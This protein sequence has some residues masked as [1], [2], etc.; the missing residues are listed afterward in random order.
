MADDDLIE[1][2]LDEYLDIHVPLGDVEGQPPGE[3]I[4]APPDE[5]FADRLLYKARRLSVEQAKYQRLRDRR[6]AEIDAWLSDRTAGTTRELGRIEQSLDLF[7]RTW[8]R[9]NPRHKTLKLPNGKLSLTKGRGRLV[10][11]DD[12][13]VVAWARANKAESLLRVEPVLAKSELHKLA[14]HPAPQDRV[15]DSKGRMEMCQTWRVL[16]PVVSTGTAGTDGQAGTEI[17]AIPG[18]RWVEPVEDRFNMTTID[19]TT[20]EET[21]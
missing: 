8:H 6:V 7:M 4:V 20:D 5:E 21:S 15:A 3:S 19:E 11:D 18:A 14:R 1:A 12:T 16:A 9:V 13:A 2:D 17:V 10:V